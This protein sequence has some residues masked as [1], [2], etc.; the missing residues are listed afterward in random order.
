M[1]DFDIFVNIVITH[2]LKKL[3]LKITLHYNMVMIIANLFNMKSHIHVTNANL[4]VPSKAT[5]ENILQQN[6][7]V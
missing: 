6:M 3:A 2:T 1:R 7:K 5:L 4:K